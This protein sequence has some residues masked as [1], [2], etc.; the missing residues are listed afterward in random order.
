R[1]LEAMGSRY[2]DVG[3]VFGASSWR[4]FLRITLPL[5]IP[6]LATSL[7]LVFAMAIE[8]YGTP[9]A[10]GRRTGFQVLVTEIELRVSDWPIDLPGASFMALL[11]VVL[12]FG[13][14]LVQRH[15]LA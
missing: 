4:S 12:S 8:E 13:A 1:T 3:R 2:S 11:L 9:A 14:F 6:G 15:L 7:L 10:L 5:S